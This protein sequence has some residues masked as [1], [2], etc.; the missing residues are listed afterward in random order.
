MLQIQNLVMECVIQ[1]L[2]ISTVVTMMVEIVQVQD[3]NLKHFNFDQ[4]GF[5]VSGVVSRFTI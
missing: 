5:R 3:F 1:K 2:L 4:I